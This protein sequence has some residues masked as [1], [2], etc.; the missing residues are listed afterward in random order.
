MSEVAEPEQPGGRDAAPGD[1]GLVQAFLNTLDREGGEEVLET[2]ELLGRWL[3]KRRLLNAGERVH[4]PADLSRARSLREALRAA[5]RHR[6]QDG[7]PRDLGE[8]DQLDPSARAAIEQAAD[9][10]RFSLVSDDIGTVTLTPRADGVDGALGRLLAICLRA[11]VDG[12][13][14]RLRVCANDGCQWA[15]Y[16]ASR[17]RSGRWCSMAICGNRN[18]VRT[19]RGR[20]RSEGDRGR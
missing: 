12:G 13:W 15:F 9:R 16:D 19:H 3:R 18:K 17:N 4:D 8:L 10:A 2:P 11:Q 14:S 20:Y 6:H 7:A 1:L 5:L